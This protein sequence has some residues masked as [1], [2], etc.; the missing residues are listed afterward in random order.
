LIKRSLG[1]NPLDVSICSASIEI[2]R[3]GRTLSKLRRKKANGI[4]TRH[5]RLRI[6]LREMGFRIPEARHVRAL[7]RGPAISPPGR[8]RS[9]VGWHALCS[10]RGEQ[11]DPNECRFYCQPRVYSVSRAKERNA[12][13]IVQPTD[14]SEDCQRNEPNQPGC[15]FFRRW[16][17]DHSEPASIRP[18]WPLRRQLGCHGRWC[19]CDFS[20]RCFSCCRLLL[21]QILRQ[22][23]SWVLRQS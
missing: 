14:R 1:G 17:A 21:L 20:W 5:S 22:T 7:N 2:K 23:F 8:Y 4:T 11:Q 18:E 13:P 6:R 15:R 19:W 9:G 10:K 12:R 3:R 16:N